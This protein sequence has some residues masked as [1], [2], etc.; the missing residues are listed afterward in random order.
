MPTHVNDQ[1]VLSFKRLF[2]SRASLP[3]AHKRLLIAVNMIGVDVPNEFI[4]GEELETAA[5]PMAV[6]FEEDTAVVFGVGRICQNCLAA[7]AAAV[8][9]A[10]SKV[11]V[12]FGTKGVFTV[13]VAA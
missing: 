6:R 9:V 10:R 5:S 7:R 4:L 12:V 13:D 11:V 2:V 3:T 8:V 1:H